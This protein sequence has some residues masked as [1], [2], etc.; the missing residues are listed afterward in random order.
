MTKIIRQ[1]KRAAESPS[2]VIPYIVDYV[3]GNIRLRIDNYYCKPNKKSIL[4]EN[5]D[6]LVILDACRY[7]SLVQEN[8]FKENCEV[9]RSQASNTTPWFRY[10]FVKQSS[11]KTEDIVYV[12]ANP[13]ASSRNCNPSI[14]TEIIDVYRKAWDDTQT[15]PADKVTDKAIQK[16]YEYPNNR[17]VVHYLQPHGPFI[18]TDNPYLSEDSYKKLQNGE[19]TLETVLDTYRECL[20]YALDEVERLIEYLNGDVV[21]TSDHGESFGE[22]GIYAHP[23]Y[24]RSRVLLDV[25]WIE[26]TGEGKSPPKSLIDNQGDRDVGKSVEEQLKHLGYK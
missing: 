19:V 21:I 17:L 10:N 12:S 22:A 20:N 6:I 14:F 7:G 13:K 8:R 11:K 4:D 25:P 18:G 24:A 9:Y 2:E 15:V 3:T 1:I 26:L 5:W 16:H 23:P